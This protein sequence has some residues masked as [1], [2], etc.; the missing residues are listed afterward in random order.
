MW[1]ILS[2]Q[3]EKTTDASQQ[4]LFTTLVVQVQKLGIITPSKT[5]TPQHSVS[6]NDFWHIP[7]GSLQDI[8]IYSSDGNPKGRRVIYYVETL[9]V[10]DYVPRKSPSFP[11]LP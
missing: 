9:V 2:T 7:H 5:L 1:K 4:T 8:Y 11:N 10:D 6:L 3:E